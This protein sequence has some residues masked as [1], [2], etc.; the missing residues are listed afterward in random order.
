MEN[1]LNCRITAAEIT[2]DDNGDIIIAGLPHASSMQYE[3]RLSRTICYD[4]LF[5]I[6]DI[7]SPR[8]FK[9]IGY[10]LD[11][12]ED[13]AFFIL[14]GDI[15]QRTAEDGTEIRQIV[16]LPP[17][18]ESLIVVRES[19]V[20]AQHIDLESYLKFT[21]Q[22]MGATPDPKQLSELKGFHASVVSMYYEFWHEQ[23]PGV[24]FTED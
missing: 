6:A 12:A 8:C 24:C 7:M 14:P 19:T 3:I 15:I 13:E 5:Q 22:Q 17:E 11:V 2:L 1:I 20:T 16:L 23:L 18:S 10:L 4:H 9:N 21:E